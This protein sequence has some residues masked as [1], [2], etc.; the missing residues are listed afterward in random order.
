VEP[1][2][3]RRATDGSAAR[4]WTAVGP[5]DAPAIVF[6]H[7]TRLSRAQWSAQ[8]RLL[9]PRFRCVALDLPG[10]GVLAHQP[11]TL[12][13]A[14]DVVAAAIKAEAASGRAVV[15]GLSLG[16]YVAIDTAH[17]HPECVDGLVLSGCSAEPRGPGAVPFL[18]LA[19]ALEH[20]PASTLDIVNRWYFRLRYPRRI[21]DPIVEGGFWGAG[22][23][24]ALRALVAARFL[25]RA[26]WLWTPVL[27]VNG[28]LDPVFGPG[29]ETLAASCRSGRHAVVGRAMHLVP[30]DRPRTFSRLVAKFADEVTRAG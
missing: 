24:Q 3:A 16:G 8:L 30:L 27:V 19:W 12:D 9:A 1:A 29:G 5:A 15:V 17:R 7:G 26:A 28:A 6:I 10:H 21:A 13:A 2:E 11:F 23:A 4:P 22:G 18:A 14:A 25:D 20:L